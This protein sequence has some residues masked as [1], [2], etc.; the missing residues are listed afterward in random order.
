MYARW[1]NDLGHASRRKWSYSVV[2]MRLLLALLAVLALAANPATAAAAQ[3]GCATHGA[4]SAMAGLDMAN[5]P[6][7]AHAGSRT[8][9]A[10]PCC[11]HAAKHGKSDQ[12]CA[13]ACA[14][15]CAVV[16]AL[17]A[18]MVSLAPR[19]AASV[20]HPGPMASLKPHDPSQLERPP[21]S[22]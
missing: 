11:D 10:D 5:M 3:A 17:P 9:V 12:S 7:M 8:S 15:T 4:P 6:G 19:L 14:T 22:I 2:S 16:T 13:Q 1:G 21:R 18:T 20:L